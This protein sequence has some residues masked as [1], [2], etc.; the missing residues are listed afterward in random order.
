MKRCHYCQKPVKKPEKAL[1]VEGERFIYFHK[2]CPRGRKEAMSVKKQLLII[3]F[4]IVLGVIFWP[5]LNRLFLLTPEAY[6]EALI[7]E[8]FTVD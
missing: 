4:F 6:T 2:D 5:W 1:D 8:G 7:K 3:L